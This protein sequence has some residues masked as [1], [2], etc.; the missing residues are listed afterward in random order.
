MKAPAEI[1][2]EEVALGFTKAKEKNRAGQESKKLLDAQ[3]VRRD[4]SLYTSTLSRIK[5]A[6]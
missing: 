3:A 5:Q 4:I 6:Q 2:K 1:R